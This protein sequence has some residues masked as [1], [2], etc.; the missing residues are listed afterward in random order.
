MAGSFGTEGADVTSFA[1]G[2]TDPVTPA[3][4]YRADSQR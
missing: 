4:A 3:E 2:A 1:G